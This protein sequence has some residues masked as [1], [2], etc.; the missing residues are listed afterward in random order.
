ME[1]KN[2]AKMHCGI[3]GIRKVL[4]L[5]L[6][7][8]G[9]KHFVNVQSFIHPGILHSREDLDRMKKAVARKEEPIYAGYQMFIQNPASQYSYKMQ[10]PLAMVGRNPTIGQAT[11]DSD[12]NAAHQNAVMWAVTGDKRY[13]EKA[14]EIVNAWSSSLKEITGYKNI[15]RSG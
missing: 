11:Y 9:F 15:T 4:I 10:G 2:I 3:A 6:C 8:T 5:V 1:V 14:I 12:A 13:A 7:I